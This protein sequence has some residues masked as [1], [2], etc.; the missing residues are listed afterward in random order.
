MHKDLAVTLYMFLCNS[1]DLQDLERLQTLVK[2]TANNM[3][4]SVTDNGHRFVINTSSSPLTPSSVLGK[5]LSGMQQ[6]LFSAHS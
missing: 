6:V 5:L 1:P 4:L 3:A 2:V